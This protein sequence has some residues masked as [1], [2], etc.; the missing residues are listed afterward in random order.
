M[1]VTLSTERPR[2]RTLIPASCALLKFV[3]FSK[4]HLTG[5]HTA[6]LSVHSVMPNQ[7]HHNG[8]G[9]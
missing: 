2:L 9:R 1:A 3:H 6:S 4:W 7:L 5:H 8:Q